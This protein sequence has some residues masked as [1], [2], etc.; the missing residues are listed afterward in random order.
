MNTNYSFKLTEEIA[1]WI[2]EVKIKNS[3]YWYIAFTNPTAGPWKSIKCKD[4]NGNIGEV[5][6][7]SRDEERPDILLVNDELQIVLIIEAKDSL[8]K[9]KN[10]NQAKKSVNV[11]L[12][13]GRILNAKKTN[14]YWGN[15]AD[16]KIITGLLWGAN[17]K[18][19][20]K[21]R[22]ELFEV[23]R[24]LIGA[25][26]SNIIY[27]NMLLG[28]EVT[29]NNKNDLIDVIGFIDINNDYFD[30]EPK[31]ILKTLGIVNK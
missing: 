18:S 4:K 21:E 5:H 26:K 14:I 11:V 8:S 28:I 25:D 17:S 6:R 29:Y 16:Y 10:D 30:I 13:L 12:E 9:L 27:N 20:P 23:Y 15:R 31:K 7:F 24:K 3:L 19:S 1:R 22:E 2:F